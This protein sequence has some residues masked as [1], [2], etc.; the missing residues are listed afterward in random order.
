VLAA[1]SQNVLLVAHHD[2][3]RSGAAHKSM[4]LCAGMRQDMTLARQERKK[5]AIWRVRA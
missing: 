2:A 4:Q 1:N 5:A 3:A